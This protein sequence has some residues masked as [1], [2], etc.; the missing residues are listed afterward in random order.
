MAQ[1]N[2]NQSTTGSKPA[3]T[4]TPAATKPEVATK[5]A[6]PAE[7]DETDEVDEIDDQAIEETFAALKTLLSTVDKLQ[8]ARQSIGDIKPLL[9]QLLDGAM[10]S[11]DELEELKAGVSGLGKLVKLYS[12]YQIALEEAQ[13]ARDLLDN[14]LKF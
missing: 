2:G 8:K 4:P 14:I 5:T 10:L 3:V 6:P 12:D 11:D 1:T 9:I 7:T 13:P